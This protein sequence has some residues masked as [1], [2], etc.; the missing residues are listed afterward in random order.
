M[1]SCLLQVALLAGPV[2]GLVALCALVSNGL[3]VGL[4]FSGGLL[5]PKLS[6]LDPLAGLKRLL[7]ARSMVEL[8]KGIVKLSVVGVSGWLFLTGH[9]ND[10]FQLAAMP[11][12][13]IGPRVGE[14]AH[15]M[16][17]QMVATLAVVSAVDY[18]YQRWQHERSMRMTKQEVK[19]EMREAEGRPE[20]KSRL[21]QRQ[22][23]ISRRRM[24]AEIPSASVVITNP[25]HFAVA[26]RY[27]AGQGGAPKVVAKGQDL[28][29]LRIRETAAAH[30]VPTVSN[31]PLA[32]SLY[33]SVEIGQEIPPALYRAVAEV[34][35]LVWRSESQGVGGRV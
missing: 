8:L 16:A 27:S 14:L 29:A 12:T 20:I 33:R 5:Q 17:V 23:E 18:A 2:L 13:S 26:L 3:Q 19:D 6:R 22:R 25:R 7:S 24:M 15:G 1:G 31:P 21:R 32:R 30:Q 28:I 11:A 9:W 4:H 35:A 34:L 10:L